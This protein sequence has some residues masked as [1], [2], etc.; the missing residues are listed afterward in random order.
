M[1]INVSVEDLGTLL[2]KAVKVV[3]RD[4]GIHFYDDYHKTDGA[5]SELI[6]GFLNS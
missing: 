6:L 3:S 1:N 4:S 2:F 5:W